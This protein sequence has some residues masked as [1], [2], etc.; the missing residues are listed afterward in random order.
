MKLKQVALSVTLICSLSLPASA[1]R[2]IN[3]M[4]GCQGLLDFLDTKLT[5]SAPHYKSSD[6]QTIRIGLKQYNEYIQKEIVTPGL[7]QF[8]KGDKTK[9]KAMQKQ[10]DTYKLG[11]V[12]GL[13]ARYPQNRLFTDYAIQ[14]NNCAKKA[15]PSGEELE[16]LKAS[17]NTLLK[18]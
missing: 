2:L 13:N 6:L 17:L 7:L 4:Q 8:S 10:V 9:A 12:E 16:N 5:S 11:L 14:V 18:L 15:V 3:D 1:G